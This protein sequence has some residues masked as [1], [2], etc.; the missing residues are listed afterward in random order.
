MENGLARGLSLVISFLASLLRLSGITDKIKSAIQKIKG[1][2]DAVLL[3]VA[4]WIADKAKKIW[5]SIKTGAASVKEKVFEWWKTKIAFKTPSGETHSLFIKGGTDSP[6]LY[7]ASDE[8]AVPILLRAADKFVQTEVA[9]PEQKR[10]YEPA[11]TNYNRIKAGLK[12]K[13]DEEK[14]KAVKE[15]SELAT[16][17]RQLLAA[18]LGG[19]A[20]QIQDNPGLLNDDFSPTPKRL[21]YAGQSTQSFKVNY[22]GNVP[23]IP[24]KAAMTEE[25]DE[26]NIKKRVTTIA[27]RYYSDGFDKGSMTDPEF[28]DYVRSRFALVVGVN[29]FRNL[30]TEGDHNEK[31]VQR[32]VAAVSFGKYSLGVIGFSWS[33]RWSKLEGG[34]AVKFNEVQAAYAKL[35]N[36]KKK[37]I[38]QY[39]AKWAKQ[40]KMVPYGLIRTKIHGSKLTTDFV[41]LL[42]KSGA[43]VYI[44]TGDDDAVSLKVGRT[45]IPKAGYDELAALTAEGLFSRFDEILNENKTSDGSLPLLVSGGY[46]FRMEI[47]G[48]DV[49]EPDALSYLAVQL[50][51]HLRSNL[52]RINRA[53][54]LV[55]F[56]EQN[57]LFLASAAPKKSKLF[58]SKS[59][60]GAALMR[61][62]LRENPDGK[63]LFDRRAAVATKS[64]R[65]LIT[66]KGGKRLSSISF[67][68][69]TG[70][71]KGLTIALLREAVKISQSHADKDDFLRRAKEL[72]PPKDGKVTGEDVKAASEFNRIVGAMYGH[73]SP[74]ADLRSMK[75]LKETLEKFPAK[76]SYASQYGP[77]FK[78]VRILLHKPPAGD[79]A[80][81]DIQAVA[82]EIGRAV[83][84]FLKAHVDF[85]K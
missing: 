35:D 1:K 45:S 14:Q 36:D 65:Y 82:A 77:D 11:R 51:L 4:H 7:V 81:E 61:S 53:A 55:Y 84:I 66:A 28:Q 74:L 44:H 57:T 64:E 31:R 78:R 42:S 21:V 67:N 19:F 54:K 16:N 48:G 30:R 79:T 80:A 41:A 12:S 39:E 6:E 23:A 75:S 83:T 24:P 8:K 68:A 50:D 20:Y 27:D 2:V 26:G 13:N 40:Q 76:K 32:V 34:A 5:G 43:G 69:T 3:K 70:K 73:Y 25:E 72:H 15:M 60:E 38:D 47:D 9:T 10:A 58:G 71:M 29:S 33:P 56:P 59:Q 22:V 17:L 63:L 62:L 18:M 52:T 49:K 46:E 85:T 37:G